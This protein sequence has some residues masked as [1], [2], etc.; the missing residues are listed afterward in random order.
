MTK[1]PP[2]FETRLARDVTDLREAQRLRYEVFVEEMGASGPLVDH[3]VRLEQDRFDGFAEHLLL[4]DR[5]R[6]EGAQVVGVYR[7]MDRDG[8]ARAGQFY[9]EDE[10]DLSPLIASGRSML[11]LGR[12]CLH[13]DYRGGAGMLLLWQA[14]GQLAQDRRIALLFGVA[15]FPGTDLEQLAQPLSLLHRDHLAPPNLR[16]TVRDGAVFEQVET[17]DRIAVM[18]DIPA[19]IKAYLRLGG[20]IGQGAY[21]D[22]AFNTTDVFLVLDQDQMNPRQRAIYTAGPRS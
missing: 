6:P 13:P 1:C 17:P 16:A 14:L 2:L 12:S 3:E 11:E 21:V 19:L 18:R 20:F 9:T 22:R 5:N 7:L 15:S 4:L 10:Y 8:A